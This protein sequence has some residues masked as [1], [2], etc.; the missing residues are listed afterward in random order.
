M[1]H[2]EPQGYQLPDFS[3]RSFL[4]TADFPRI[5]LYMP[6]T[7]TFSHS[8]T[9]QP[10]STLEFQYFSFILQMNFCELRQKREK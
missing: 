8:F 3:L 7:M 10:A 4:Y 6:K 2:D 5:F 1:V 9:K